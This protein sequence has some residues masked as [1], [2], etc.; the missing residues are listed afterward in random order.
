MIEYYEL[1]ESKRKVSRLNEELTKRFGLTIDTK[2]VE[3][4]KF[5]HEHYME[6]R[7]KILSDFG[8]AEALEREDYAKAVLL[9]EAASLFLR[10]IAPTRTKSR[11]R[12]RKERK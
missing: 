10:E 8:I 7:Q 3:T 11:T 5:V 4:V 1:A 9:S 12:S 6:K 2:S